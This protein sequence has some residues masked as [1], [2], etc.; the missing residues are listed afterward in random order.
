V[1][2]HVNL[3]QLRFQ[4][5]RP[6]FAA[7]LLARVL[8]AGLALL[9]LV[10]GH[11]EWRVRGAAAHVEELRAERASE[12]TRLVELATLYPA[13]H[14]DAAL[15]AEVAGLEL[16]RAAKTRLLGLLSSQSLGNTDGFS[17]QLTGVARRRV[18]GLWL[19][20]LHIE[21]GGNQLALAGSALDAALVPR[22]LRALGQE[23]VFSGRDFQ[24]LRIERSSEQPGL[25][26]WSV[27]TRPAAGENAGLL[28]GQTEEAS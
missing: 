20:E 22:F 15:E 3:Y 10:F 18:E 9:L 27:R 21:A 7:A 2:Q 24:R 14:V 8:G 4:R 26:E 12:S 16:E 25:V 13:R 23:P 19:R 5:V 6:P 11:A 17:A 1:K 28:R